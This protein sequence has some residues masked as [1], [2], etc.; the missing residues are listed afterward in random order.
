MVNVKRISRF[1]VF[2]LFASGIVAAKDFKFVKIEQDVYLQASG[3]VRVVDT[4]TYQFQ[5]NYHNAFVS[6]QP[7]P[8]GNVSFEKVEALDGKAF[9]GSSVEG[10]KVKWSYDATDEQR[11]F[12]IVYNLTDE[13]K[14]SSDA[15]QFDRQVLYSDH[16]RVDNYIVRIH[17]PGPNPSLFRVFVF[18]TASRIGKLDINTPQGLATVKLNPVG[19]GEF[20]RTRVFLNPAQFSFRNINGK[21]FSTWINEVKNETRGF[22]DASSAAINRGSVDSGGFAPPP[23][24]PP[25]WQQGLPFVPVVLLGG[26]IWTRFQRFGKEPVVQDIGQYYR[27]PAQEIAPSYVPYVVNQANPG[28]SA[29]GVA[30][31]ATLIDFTRKGYLSLINVH[32]DGVF[33]IGARDETHFKLEKRPSNS[34]KPGELSSF[35]SE[36]WQIIE[37]ANGGDGILSPTELKAYF[38]QSPSL[39]SSLASL[40]RDSYEQRYGPLLDQ[41]S[42]AQK[43]MTIVVGV[44]GAVVCIGAAFFL[45]LSPTISATLIAVGVGSG[46]L[47]AVAGASLS[48]WNAD[49]L[50]NARKWLA[51]KRFLSDFS[52]MKNAPP[53]HFKLWDYHF[54]YATALGVATQY[55]GNIKR[56]AQSNPS[57]V[58]IPYW[59]GGGGFDNF[60]NVASA[61]ESVNS[62]SDIAS[63]LS[64]LQ[65]ALS[66]VSSGSGGG[67]G[68]DSG[69]GSSGGGG[70]DGAS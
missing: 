23:P 32:H 9:Y 44:I 58:P 50:L 68:G 18:N 7:A 21:T 15:A 49:K 25:P 62:L 54:V 64:S 27:E 48:K 24:P 31:S 12:R 36:L 20:V 34:L 1:L 38:Q 35:E 8:G 28:A 29:L 6:I 37:A 4:R 63:N 39:V 33:G 30:L 67:F 26:F 43:T 14:V 60:G 69:G 55:I 57:L 5:G 17:T 2:L 65:S 45:P 47:T 22:R 70:G 41:S 66:D 13:L 42:E 40:P 53:E 19:E 11:T 46:I 56:I 10:N 51:Y 59:I 3:N 16:K 61:L 52:Q